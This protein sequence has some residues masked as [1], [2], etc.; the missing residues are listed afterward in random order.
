[1]PVAN[2]FTFSIG[3][4]YGDVRDNSLNDR[5][6]FDS[7]INFRILSHHNLS[8]FVSRTRDEFK[9]WNDVAYVFLTITFPERN[10]FI[11]ALYDQQQKSTRVTYLKD[12]QN[13]LRTF[14]TQATVQN[15]K[16]S[17]A[18]ELDMTYPTPIGDFGGRIN[19]QNLIQEARRTNNGKRQRKVLRFKIN[20]KQ[21]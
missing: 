3:T 13:K 1:M 10:D 20:S 4:N 5:Y 21:L 7:T 8:L 6:G 19:A 14:R 17:Q 9:Q 16:N 15:N 2:A 11:S 18:G 12:N